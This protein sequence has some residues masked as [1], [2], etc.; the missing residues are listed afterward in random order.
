MVEAI[1]SE[2]NSIRFIP[3]SEMTERR[4]EIYSVGTC[5]ILVLTDVEPQGGVKNLL[6]CLKDS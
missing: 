4:R 6:G 5:P 1:R 3:N 2:S